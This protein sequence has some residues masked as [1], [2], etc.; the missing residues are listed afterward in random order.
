MKGSG[1]SNKKEDMQKA[2]IFSNIIFNDDL[3]TFNSDEFENN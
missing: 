1:S 2:R 3:R